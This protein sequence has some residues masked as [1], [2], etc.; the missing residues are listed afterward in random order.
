MDS[1]AVGGIRLLPAVDHEVMRPG[2]IGMIAI[3]RMQVVGEVS[4][5]YQL[6]R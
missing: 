4:P 2:L 5:G 3:S 1:A 6:F